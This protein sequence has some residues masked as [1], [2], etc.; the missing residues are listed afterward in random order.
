MEIISQIHVMLEVNEGLSLRQ[1]S[2][3]EQ[4]LREKFG[5]VIVHVFKLCTN[6]LCYQSFRQIKKTF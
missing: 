6:D 5:F 4:R 1:V 2:H 3:L